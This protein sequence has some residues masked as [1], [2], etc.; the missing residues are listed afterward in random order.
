MEQK[1]LTMAEYIE[2][3]KFRNILEAKAEMAMG[4]P[5]QV[6]YNTIA[7]LDLIPAADVVEVKHGHKVVHKRHRG[8][9]PIECPVC[10]GKFP[11]NEPYSEDVEYCSE[12]GKKLDDTFQ[13][14]CPNCG[15]KMDAERKCE[16]G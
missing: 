11:S 14:Y 7:M 8:F 9:F 12:C 16:D 10:K 6:F 5:K 13:N 4:T 15:A 2:R 1:V 3:D